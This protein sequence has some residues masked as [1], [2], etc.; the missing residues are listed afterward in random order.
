MSTLQVCGAFNVN[1][2]LRLMQAKSHEAPGPWW[3][4]VNGSMWESNVHWPAVHFGGWFDIFLIGQLVTFSAFQHTSSPGA[5]GLQS[6]VVD[7]LGHCQSAAHF[8]PEH[9]ID[10]RTA[11][12]V[13]QVC[14]AH[15]HAPLDSF[16]ASPATHGIIRSAEL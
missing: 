9:T 11:L 5:T 6:I 10:G 8:F 2:L 16:C 7:P 14:K 3:D 12:P 13:L 4:L 15:V 1:V